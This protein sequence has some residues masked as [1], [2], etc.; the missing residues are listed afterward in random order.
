MTILFLFGLSDKA[1]VK[2]SRQTG[3]ED[4]LFKDP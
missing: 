4:D 1:K 2:V 3:N